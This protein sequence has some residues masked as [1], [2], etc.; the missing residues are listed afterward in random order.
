MVE[1]AKCDWCSGNTDCAWC[2]SV[3][4]EVCV[5]SASSPCVSCI[6]NSPSWCN[7]NHYGCTTG[8]CFQDWRL[9]PT[10]AN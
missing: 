3:V 1:I 9:N 2:T 5:S 6:N 4:N 10:D 7:P 8:D